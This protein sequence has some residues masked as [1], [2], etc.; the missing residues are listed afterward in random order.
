MVGASARGGG[1]SVEGHLRKIWWE[2][3]P[4]EAVDGRLRK[5]SGIV[6]VIFWV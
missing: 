3:A 6:C 4:E 1:A 2:R 5:E